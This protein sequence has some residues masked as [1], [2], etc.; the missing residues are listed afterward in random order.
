[1]KRLIAA[2]LAAPLCVV[3]AHAQTPPPGEGGD[4]LTLAEA[5]TEAKVRAPAPMAATAGIRAAEAGRA[6]AGLRPNPSIAIDTENALGTG[7]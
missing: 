3:I 2:A 1:M 5:L 4:V 7:P 6:V